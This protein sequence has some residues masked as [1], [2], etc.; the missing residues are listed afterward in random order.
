MSFFKS[1]VEVFDWIKTYNKV[2]KVVSQSNESAQIHMFGPNN[3]FGEGVILDSE[4]E[5]D[6][7]YRILNMN[8]PLVLCLNYL[9]NNTRYLYQI[10]IIVVNKK[11][12]VPDRIKFL[13]IIP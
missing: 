12:V 9:I 10:I 6:V 1:Q 3:H 8:A 11:F 5:L 4:F 7:L 2:L 13:L